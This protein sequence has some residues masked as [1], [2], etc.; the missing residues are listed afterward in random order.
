MDVYIRPWLKSWFELCVVLCV[1]LVFNGDGPTDKSPC[2]TLD[3]YC[4]KGIFKLVLP[5]PSPCSREPPLKNFH[6]FSKLRYYPTNNLWQTNYLL[7]CAMAYSFPG[8]YR[9]FLPSLH[10]GVQ[11][12]VSVINQNP[13]SEKFRIGETLTNFLQRFRSN[14]RQQVLNFPDSDL[15]LATARTSDV[16]TSFPRWLPHVF[17]RRRQRS[18]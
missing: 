3:K 2:F 4:R 5:R 10:P 6:S 16:P 7:F 13:S 12:F 8:G 9:P 17:L 15:Q 1:V 14:F 11:G 18:R